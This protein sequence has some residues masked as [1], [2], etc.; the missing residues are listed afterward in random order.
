[1]TSIARVMDEM[2][3]RVVPSPKDSAKVT[4]IAETTLARTRAAASHYP[5][6]RGVILG[7]SFAKGTWLTGHVDLDI[8]VKLDPGTPPDEFERVGLEIGATATRGYPR[9]KMWAQHPYTEANIDGTKVNIV[10]C[11]DVRQGEWKS[12]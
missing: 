5:T 4:R 7:G 3:R 11:F 12:A 1:M 2:R 9:G 8:F 6:S 10:P